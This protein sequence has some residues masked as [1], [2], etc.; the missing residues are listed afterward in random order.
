MIEEGP[1]RDERFVP[2]DRDMFTTTE[3]WIFTVLGDVHPPNRI[4]SYLKYVPGSGPW[5]DH[6]GRT[7]RRAFTTYTVREL[8]SIMEDLRTNKPEYVYYDPTVGNEVI[9]PPVDAVAGYWKTSEGLMKLVEREESGHATPLELKAIEMVRWLVEQ[10]GLRQE[11]LGITGSLL[12][13]IHH[14]RS[15]MDIVV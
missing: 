6:S 12:L 2:R 7:Y 9:A 5:R 14:E 4:W 8:L 13:G 3:G 15:D 11:G 1:V 10:A